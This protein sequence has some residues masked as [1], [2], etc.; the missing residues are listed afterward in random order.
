M[1]TLYQL[2]WSHY[3]EKVR[4]ALD[5]KGLEWRAVEV[6]PFSKRQM[7][8]LPCKTTLDSGSRLHTM[9]TIHDERTGAMLGESSAILAYLERQYP[10]PALYPDSPPDRDEVLRWLPWLDTE[11]GLPARRLAYTQ[12]ALEYPGYLAELFLPHLAPKGAAS[13]FKARLA[14]KIIGGV[15]TQ[16]FRFH[17]VREDRVYEQLEQCL[18][19]V[20]RRLDAQRFLVGNRF[21]AADLA[22]AALVRPTTIVPFFRNHPHLQNLYAWRD[23]LLR[24]Q[25]RQAQAGYESALHAVR[26]SRGWALGRV[27]WLP[28]PAAATLI[29]E[30]PAIPSARNDQRAVARWPLITGLL[31]YRRLK[32]T[33]GLTRSPQRLPNASNTD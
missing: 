9:P 5:Y 21:T 19:F 24:E 11:I 6:E 23:S 1:I 30:I 32:A 10:S 16:R 14:G 25:G 12:I 22:F 17:L 15:L 8:H 4:W 26:Q 13:G 31:W 27:S 20:A 28:E 2:H 18:L 3:V 33:C 7:Q 29:K